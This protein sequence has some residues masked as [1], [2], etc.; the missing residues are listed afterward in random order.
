MWRGLALLPGSTTQTRLRF[1]TTQRV[2]GVEAR[3]YDSRCREKTKGKQTNWVR[4]TTS[5]KFCQWGSYGDLWIIT[6]A[7]IVLDNVQESNQWAPWAQRTS[8]VG[9]SCRSK[10][11]ITRSRTRRLPRH[12]VIRF[13]ELKRPVIIVFPLIQ[14]SRRQRTIFEDTCLTCLKWQPVLFVILFTCPPDLFF[15]DGNPTA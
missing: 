12:M 15:H 9:R 1:M 14:I 5:P 6:A 2:Y 7:I 10:S 3:A 4:P 11:P 8:A 13:G